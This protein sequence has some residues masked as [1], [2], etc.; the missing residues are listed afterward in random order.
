MY[1]ILI[2][3]TNTIEESKRRRGKVLEEKEENSPF[4]SLP[5]TVILWFVNDG[6]W[7]GNRFI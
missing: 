6:V 1:Y 4:S 5:K 7:C 2:E 3:E